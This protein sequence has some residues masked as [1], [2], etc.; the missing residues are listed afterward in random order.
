MQ[1]AGI[2][3]CVDYEDYLEHT[4]LCNRHQFDR[5]VVVTDQIQPRLRKLCEHAEVELVTS[6]RLRAGAAAFN[7]GK[8]INDGLANIDP[9]AWILHLDADI[10]LPPS[11]RSELLRVPLDTETLYGCVRLM[12]PSY[13]AWQRYQRAGLFGRGWEE[14]P[15]FEYV[16]TVRHLWEG[17]E[18]D[19]PRK[20]YL[21]LGFF[22]L[23]SPL[24]SGLQREPAY[25]EGFPDAGGSDL[26]FGL[27]FAR[28]ACLRHIQV[29]HLPSSTAA[30]AANWEG[31]RSKPFHE[32]E[33]PPLMV[34]SLTPALVKRHDH[35]DGVFVSRFANRGLAEQGSFA[36]TLAHGPW[37][38]YHENG[39]IE[40]RGA[41]RQGVPHGTWSQYSPA[42]S[43]VAEHPY[44]KGRLHGRFRAWHP[45]GGLASEGR[46][47][48]GR[49]HGRVTEWHTN[50]VRALVGNYRSGL[51]HG[52]FRAWHE[53]GKRAVEM[54]YSADQPHGLYRIWY[55]DGTPM[56]R[57]AYWHGSRHG[58]FV[59][60]H[61]NGQKAA[62]S[63]FRNSRQLAEGA[64][65]PRLGAEDAQLVPDG[66]YQSLEVVRSAREARTRPSPPSSTPVGT[67]GHTP[68]RHVLR[69]RNGCVGFEGLIFDRNRLFLHD[70]IYRRSFAEL[71]RSSRGFR[72]DWRGGRARVPARLDLRWPRSWSERAI[73][74]HPRHQRSSQADT[75][76][77]VER[78]TRLASIVHRVSGT[79][80]H[81]LLESLPR[82]LQ[83]SRHLERDPDLK[84]LID[85]DFGGSFANTWTEQY[86]Q[87]LG[88]ASASIVRYD[89]SRIYAA[90][91]LLIPGPVCCG[92]PQRE[93]LMAI[94]RTLLPL[95]A[96]HDT[97]AIIAV[98]RANAS[99]R[100]ARHWPELVEGLRQLG[101]SEV[102]DFNSD[103]WRVR[104]QIALFSSARAVIGVHGAGLAN[105]VFCPPGTPVAE[106]IP[107]DHV[108]GRCFSVLA[109]ILGL[110]HRYHRGSPSGL[111]DDFDV[112]VAEV[113]ASFTKQLRASGARRS[114]HACRPQ[115]DG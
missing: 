103:D 79:Y 29:I 41:Y 54:S 21:P 100:R 10:A 115:P 38:E 71:C 51:K 58:W 34:N 6:S 9:R 110:Q 2:T 13:A 74:L 7:K 15:P 113:I 105:T 69:V 84:V 109:S 92:I 57:A 48:F 47:K 37:T 68:E 86:L 111:Q 31:R 40:G 11:F 55:A 114:G 77:Y 66:I 65:W 83:V 80:Y 88:V 62:Q 53:N 90:R 3:V 26:E 44:R 101:G 25:P 30:V 1:L 104:D 16:P 72:L 108:G 61:E 23:F 39:A 49:L 19:G 91:Q 52:L 32:V 112:P 12:C 81:W 76:P 75:P 89:P 102:I 50:G 36:G 4:L 28:V 18:S 17:H 20:R 87:L 93:S 82:L 42:D 8:A 107:S 85:F 70:P 22:Q 43:L 96:P 95:A 33:A 45:D 59:S 27:K 60:W 99:C 35:A 24:A 94:R 14:S 56:V 73:H 106:I 67:R 98:S 97:R 46:Y 63:R 64:A 5:Y 78:F